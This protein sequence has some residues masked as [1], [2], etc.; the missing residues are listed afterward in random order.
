MLYC[1]LSIVIFFFIKC[2]ALHDNSFEGTIEVE[3]KAQS[4]KLRPSR[5]GFS[6]FN[7]YSSDKPID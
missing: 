6:P 1:L 7:F 3:S 5:F 4:K 2:Y